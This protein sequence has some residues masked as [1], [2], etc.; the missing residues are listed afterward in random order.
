MAA[1]IGIMVFLVTMIISVIVYN[2][3]G[4]IK[5]EEGFQ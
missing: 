1:V 4:S 5:D 2:N 3:M